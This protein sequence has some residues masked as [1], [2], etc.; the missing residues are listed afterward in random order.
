MQHQRLSLF[1]THHFCDLESRVELSAGR[2][3][4]FRR[5]R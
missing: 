3:Y 2:F 4:G 5:G 1:Y